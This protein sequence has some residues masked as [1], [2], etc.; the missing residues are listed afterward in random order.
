MKKNNR[1]LSLLSYVFIGLVLAFIYIPLTVMVVFSFNELQSQTVYQ[2]LTLKWY[3]NIFENR[4]LRSALIN[5]IIVSICATIFSTII[6]TFA[7]IAVSRQKKTFRELILQGNNI[8]ILSPDIVTAV[9]FLLFFI[10]LAIEPNLGTMI[11]AHIAI[12][13][14]YAFV[15]IYPKVRGLDPSIIEAAQDLGATPFKTLWK[16]IIPQLY[17]TILAGAAISFT[18][19]FDDYIISSL[20]SGGIQNISIYLY[21]L[22][23]GISP[24][25][26]ALSTIIML[27]IGIKIIY[28]LIKNKNNEGEEEE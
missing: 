13:T 4:D 24:S 6:A 21:S 12:C 10:A 8:P 16:V 14:P 9:A 1:R 25:I 15:T 3:L 22:T 5:T 2:G 28:D 7:A 18:I 17:G 26:N 27:V 20:T 11:M 23:R 19:S